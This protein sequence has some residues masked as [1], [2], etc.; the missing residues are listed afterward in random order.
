MWPTSSGARGRTPA[1]PVDFDLSAPDLSFV[2]PTCTD[3]LRNGSETDV[4]CGGPCPTCADGQKCGKGDMCGKDSD[5]L[6]GKCVG[7]YNGS[8]CG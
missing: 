5:C 1:T 2:A 7:Y 6:S 3:R 8:T 4:D